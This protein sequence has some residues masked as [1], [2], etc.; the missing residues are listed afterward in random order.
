ML[1]RRQVSEKDLNFTLRIE[2]GDADEGILDIYDAANTMYGLA[3][4]TNLVSHAFSNN[5]EVKK[6]GDSAI[7]VKIFIHPSRKGCFEE[8]VK[9]V[10][11]SAVTQKIG[12]SVI[13]KN[14]FDYLTWCWSE[15]V[16]IPYAPSTPFVRKI[17]SN[18][19]KEGF[20][21]D[22]AFTLE[23][24]FIYMQK[25]I[26]NNPDAKIYIERPMVGDILSLDSATFNY[27]SETIIESRKFNIIGNVTT[28]NILSDFGRMY[29]DQDKKLISFNL[30]EPKDRIRDLATK[31]MNDFT[32]KLPGKVVFTVSKV[33]NKSGI[34]RRYIV[35]DVQPV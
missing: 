4:A 3:R 7:G 31:S 34:L 8:Q 33:T 16:G 2:G 17:Y 15:A 29:S 10:F 11:S 26:K 23:K 12:H 1:E 18:K 27:V 6:K 20:I 30:S 22:I 25:T 32:K 24:P 9:I 28:F 35:H 13:N 19:K 14:F 21:H 5:D